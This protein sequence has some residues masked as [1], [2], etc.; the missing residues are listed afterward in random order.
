MLRTP[1]TGYRGIDCSA[2]SFKTGFKD[3]LIHCALLNK[4]KPELLAYDKLIPTEAEKNIRMAM[5]AAVTYFGAAWDTLR[6]QDILKLDE[7]SMWV[8]TSE[9]YVGYVDLRRFA[10]SGQELT[11][12]MI[13]IHTHTHTHIHTHIYTH[14]PHRQ[15]G[16][17]SLLNLRLRC[18]P[19]QP[20]TESPIR[21]RRNL[22]LAESVS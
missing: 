2:L 11:V 9:F 4:F 17:Q 15:C 3:G 13:D 7:K 10:V 20:T 5:D 19:Y 1:Q 22:R 14:T 12:A 16:H 8:F 6:P 21:S 18:L